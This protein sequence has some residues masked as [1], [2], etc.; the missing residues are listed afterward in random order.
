MTVLAALCVLLPLVWLL[1]ACLRLRDLVSRQRFVLEGSR[2]GWG[3]YVGNLPPAELPHAVSRF[4][5]S[6]LTAEAGHVRDWYWGLVGEA[7]QRMAYLGVPTGA[8]A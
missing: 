7:R 4:R 1:V 8:L 5:E 2:I 3:A 6:A